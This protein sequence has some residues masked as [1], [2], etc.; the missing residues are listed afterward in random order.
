ML[1]DRQLDDRRLE[2]FKTNLCSLTRRERQVFDL[3][4]LG[5]PS[6]SI[7]RTLGIALRT[8]EVYRVKIRIKLDC[9]THE[10]VVLATRAGL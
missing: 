3:V 6:K 10:F 2:K 9:S 8:V 1:A 7:A 4:I 5:R